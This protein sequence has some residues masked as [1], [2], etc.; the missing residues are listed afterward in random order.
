[1]QLPYRRGNTPET[2]TLAATWRL[3]NR[4]RE[5]AAA[6]EGLA[7]R[8]SIVPCVL[9]NPDGRPTPGWIR[10][11]D[12]DLAA[13]LARVRP[14]SDRGVLLSPFDPLLWDR[15]RVK[16]LF[17]FDPILEIFKPAPQRIYGYY[18][19]PVLAGDRLGARFDLKAERKE[20]TLRVLSCRF[21]NRD[22]SRTA[23]ATDIQAAHAALSRY[24]EAL[25]LEPRGWRT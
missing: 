25:R 2:G 13:R 20:G 18:C 6:L 24:A 1:M 8:G 15:A 23:R 5:I 17:D 16:R 9:E 4:K 12:L 11:A 21:E 3:V 7:A 10:P 22:D 14:P 19:M